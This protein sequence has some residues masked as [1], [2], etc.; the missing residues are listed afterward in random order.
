MSGQGGG[1]TAGLECNLYRYDTGTRSIVYVAQVNNRDSS[2][3][4]EGGTLSFLAGSGLSW[5]TTPEGSYLLFAS[6]SDLT[7]YS[8]AEAAGAQQ[9]CPNE[10]KDKDDHCKEVYRYH[11]EPESATGGSVV[12]VSCDPSGAAPE[13]NAHFALGAYGAAPAGAPVRAISNDGSYVFFDS[14]DPLVTGADNHTQDVFEWETQ[15][16]GGCAL[17]RGCV[18]LISSGDD[19]SPSYFLGYERGRVERVLRHTRPVGVAGHR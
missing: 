18:H 11:Y 13:S 3:G 5:Y 19:P 12:C 4:H 7:G 10:G 15:G 9:N 6:E 2:T 1:Q 17:A 8:T 16:T 14:A